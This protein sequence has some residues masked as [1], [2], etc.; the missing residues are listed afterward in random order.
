[1]K[2]TSIRD[3][4]AEQPV[5]RDLEP[6]DI[7]LIAGCARN[8]VVEAGTFLAR[9][10]DPA[11]RFFVLRAGKVALAIQAPT[12]PLVVETLGTGDLV[13]WSWLF[14]PHRFTYDVEAVE[15]TRMV[16]VEA[17]CLV[18]KCEQDPA[19][20]YRLMKRFSQ[21][22]VERLYATRL[23]LLDLYGGRVAD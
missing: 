3:L 5:L 17:T 9:E 18:A 8:E 11:D 15:R 20:G 13:G 19:F 1:M 12:G 6:A 22:L 23:R 16:T 10:G 21:V 14:P 2:I 4:L 7:D